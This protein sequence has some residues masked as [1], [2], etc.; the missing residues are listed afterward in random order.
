MTASAQES[1]LKAFHA[2]HPMAT[3]EAFGGGRT[4]DGLSSYEVLAARVAGGERV[5]DL[6]CG[7]GALLDLLASPGRQ[8]T[9]IDLS[10]DSLAVARRR[11]AL[12]G[13]SL[14]EGRAQELPFPDN[15]VDACTSHMALMLMDEVD[16]VAEEI[17]RVLVPGGTL[18]C[19]LGGGSAGGEAFEVFLAL[20]R[21]VIASA[22]PEQRIP[23]LGDRRTRD[24]AGLDEILGPAGFAPVAW[25]T[26]VLDLSAPV[27][28]LWPVV[29]CL[30][31][32]LPLP[33]ATVETL[34]SEFTTEAAALARPDGTIPC[35]FRLHIATTS[36][37][38]S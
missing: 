30:Y 26:V 36:L 37:L 17:A 19:A 22:P 13:A 8:L 29:S 9:G 4:P 32:V 21:P 2:E 38:P 1:F 15:G 14:V 27:H 31:D 6:G 18:A 11:P 10:P 16:A 20:L 3:S 34:R 7:D 33:S 35:G 24:R 25:E 5:L 23:P 28:E 12:A